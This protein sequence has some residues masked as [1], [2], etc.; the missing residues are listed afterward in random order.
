MC[1]NRIPYVKRAEHF[2]LKNIKREVDCIFEALDYAKAFCYMGGEILLHPDLPELIRYAERYADRIGAFRVATNGTLIPSSETV[3]A[4]LDIRSNVNIEIMLSDYGDLSRKK[5]E[6][7]ELC[8]KH[9]IPLRVDKYFG[10]NQYFGGWVDTGDFK[11]YGYSE[12]ELDEVWRTCAEIVHKY[13]V[14]YKGKV[15]ACSRFISGVNAGQT[16]FPDGV[17]DLYDSSAADERRASLIKLRELSKNYCKYC[18][19]YNT[20]TAKRFPAAEQLQ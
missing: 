2:P 4:L 20:R 12:T 10:E 13:V 18:G 6:L 1:Y 9:N 15:V 8:S 16:D 11:D 7:A 17:M 19:G 14:V 5:L 3:K